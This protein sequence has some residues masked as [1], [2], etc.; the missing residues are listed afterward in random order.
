MRTNAKIVDVSEGQSDLYHAS[1]N[2]LYI[3]N[4]LKKEYTDQKKI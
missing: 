1:N 4:E 2:P 3:T